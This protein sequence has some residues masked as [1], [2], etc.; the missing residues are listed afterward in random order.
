MVV[1]HFNK[2]VLGRAG[3]SL[4]DAKNPLTWE[5]TIELAKR[6]TLDTGG[7]VSQ[8]GLEAWWARFWWHVPRQLGLADVYQ[9]DEHVLKLDHPTAIEGLQWL[10]DLR[11]KHRV[12]RPP[13]YPGAATG[14]ETGKLGL[15]A[16]G[17]WR[18]GTFR[19]TMQDEWDW[20]PLP[21]FASKKRVATGQASPVIL[22]NASK[23]KDAAWELM[24]YLAG[25]VGQELAMER[26][27][28]QPILK[29]QHT[30]P[31]FTKHRPPLNPQVAVAEVQ[32]AVPSPYGPSYNDVQALV[33]KVMAPVYLG[34]QTA[35]QAIT[36]AAPE[37]RSIIDETKRQ[38]G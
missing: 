6:L 9:G 32:Y 4:P 37:F 25:P 8:W 29:Q 36:A 10:A 16:G 17:V 33:D 31:A 15:D 1:L 26:G 38:F 18:A 11:L 14:F 2:N 12:S 19:T 34:E 23:A 21:Q 5:Q 3:V 24:K 20:A 7:S 22:G 30:S 27:I 35:R 28:S 13:G